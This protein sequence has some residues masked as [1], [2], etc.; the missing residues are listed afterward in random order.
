[1]AL[2][3]HENPCL[4]TYILPFKIL[5]VNFVRNRFIKSTPELYLHSEPQLP[6]CLLHNQLLI[7]YNLQVF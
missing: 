4:Q 3:G 1:M 7:L 5:P 6:E 2:K